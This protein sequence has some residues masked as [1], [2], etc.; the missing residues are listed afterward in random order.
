MYIFY[1]FPFQFVVLFEFQSVDV[2]VLRMKNVASGRYLAMDKNGTVR[3]LVNETFVWYMDSDP[4][5]HDILSTI[6][7]M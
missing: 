2:G 1:F 5:S 4:E 3:G 6:K 7:K